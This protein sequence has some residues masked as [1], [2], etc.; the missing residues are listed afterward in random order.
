[1]PVGSAL[2][3]MVLP[4]GASTGRQNG[5]QSLPRKADDHTPAGLAAVPTC[6]FAHNLSGF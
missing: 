4:L 6:T 3:L 5:V 1:M 2:L